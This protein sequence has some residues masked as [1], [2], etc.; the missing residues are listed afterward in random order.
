[1]DMSMPSTDGISGIDYINIAHP[2]DGDPDDV[3]G[4]SIMGFSTSEP[5]MVTVYR[6]IFVS[7]QLLNHF[8]SPTISNCCAMSKSIIFFHRYDLLMESDNV[9]ID[10]RT[11]GKFM[12]H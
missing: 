9:R 10:R 5:S 8:L 4:F 7:T 2:F 11:K 6:I 3:D 12:V 1:M